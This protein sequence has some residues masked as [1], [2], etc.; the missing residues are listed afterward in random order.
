MDQPVVCPACKTVSLV[1]S[2]R[3]ASRSTARSAAASGSTAVARQDHD[4][5]LDGAVVNRSAGRD[6]PSAAPH[7]MATRTAA[8]QERK[9]EGFLSDISISTEEVLMATGLFPYL[10]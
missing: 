4:R 1:M 5:S 7:A 3:Q 10:H 2:E 8:Q 9:R 6:A